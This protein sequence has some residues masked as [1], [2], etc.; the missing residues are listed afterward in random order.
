M[1]KSE[2]TAEMTDLV[3]RAQREPE[4]K[5]DLALVRSS[6]RPLLAH[7]ALKRLVPD[8]QSRSKGAETAER[9]LLVVVVVL[10]RWS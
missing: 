4:P 3:E 7:S 6:R 2:K 9:L 8:E 1:T 5:A 10:Q